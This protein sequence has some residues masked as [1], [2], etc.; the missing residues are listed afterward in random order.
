MMHRILFLLLISTN[1]LFAQD[2]GDTEILIKKILS[3]STYGKGELRVIMELEKD[4]VE[5]ALNEMESSTEFVNPSDGAKIV[6]SKKEKKELI[7]GIRSQYGKTIDGKFFNGHK[8]ISYKYIKPYLE[9]STSRVNSNRVMMITEP[10]YIRNGEICMIYTLHLCCD[11]G[12]QASL[13][14]Y[15]KEKGNWNK[16]I[17]ISQGLF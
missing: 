11:F 8:W 9:Q 1:G 5:D 16:W 14:F 7:R 12:G 13:W 15:K 6:I 17:P 10:V 3:D 2:N 4:P